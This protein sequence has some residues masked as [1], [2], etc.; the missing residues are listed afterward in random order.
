MKFKLLEDVAIADSAFEAYGKTEKELFENAGLA[1]FEAMADT[2]K[3]K[4][5]TKKTIVVS[6]ENQEMLLYNFLSELVYLKDKS[7][8]VFCKCSVK[9]SKTKKEQNVTAGVWCAPVK[10]LD[11][12]TIRN[13]V[14]AIT[15]HLF[16][17]EKNQE[18][19]KATIVLDV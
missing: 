2:K 10:K 9:L 8:M 18:G 13:D 12:Q 4:C 14:K 3:L 1:L 5:T 15:F 16:G 6:G 17:I 19:Y 11:F 7:H